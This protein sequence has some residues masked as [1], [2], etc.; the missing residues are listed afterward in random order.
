MTTE[1]TPAELAGEALGMTKGGR[2]YEAIVAFP[3]SVNHYWRMWKGRMVISTEGRKY[4]DLIA[5]YSYPKYEGPL[6]G[7]LTV[8]VKA[9]M[10]DKRRRDI[11][12]LCKVLLDSFTHAKIWNDDSQIDDLRIVRAGVE[13]PGRVEVFIQEI[14]K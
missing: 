8:V 11:D 1:L 2:R 3:P 6:T 12:N 14:S 10:P 13:K 7:R 5:T 9:Y 4:R